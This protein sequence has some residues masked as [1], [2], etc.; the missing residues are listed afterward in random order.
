MLPARRDAHAAS[1]HRAQIRDDI[2]EQVA[3]DDHVEPFR[4]LHEPHGRRIDVVVLAG[5]CRDTGA[6][7]ISWKARSQRP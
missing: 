3:R 6:W 5:K 7:P 4:V 2:P 1:D